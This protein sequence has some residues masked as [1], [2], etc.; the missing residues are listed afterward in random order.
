MEAAHQRTLLRLFLWTWLWDFHFPSLS[1]PPGSWLC[2]WKKQ[3]FFPQESV[4]RWWQGE[5]QWMIPM[6]S[7][8]KNNKS[9]P[10]SFGKSVSLSPHQRMHSPTAC[11]S[12]RMRNA[13]K[14]L[15]NVTEVLRNI[16]AA[17]WSRCGMLQG[18][19]E[20]LWN[21]TELS[22]K[23]HGN[24]SE[25]YGSV[26]YCY[27]TITENIDFAYHELNFN[28]YSSLK[29]RHACCTFHCTVWFPSKKT[30]EICPFPNRRYKPPNFPLEQ[31]KNENCL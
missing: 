1:C 21:F 10:K 6:V 13:T 7:N 20:T 16:M 5:V 23:C 27:R 12:C 25:H 9:S 4:D 2:H 29:C 17:L 28:F 26:A 18:I 8:I 30:K 3:C 19:T 22:W 11:A 14:Q 31:W 24:V 15:Q